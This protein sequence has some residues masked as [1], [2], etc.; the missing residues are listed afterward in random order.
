MIKVEIVNGLP[1]SRLTAFAWLSCLF[2]DDRISNI[3]EPTYVHE[4]GIVWN[5][6][7]PIDWAILQEGHG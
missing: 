6:T 5:S 7:M 4:E 3:V 2:S 1:R